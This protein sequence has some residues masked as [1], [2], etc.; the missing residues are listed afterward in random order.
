MRLRIAAGIFGEE[1]QRGRP[2]NCRQQVS[3]EEEDC[4]RD[5]RELVFCFSKTSRLEFPL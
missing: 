4:L 2:S 3:I 1:F 5:S